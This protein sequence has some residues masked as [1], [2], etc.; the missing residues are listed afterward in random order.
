[1]I[2]LNTVK[3]IIEIS[4]WRDIVERPHFRSNINPTNVD[5]KEIIGS[6]Q[7]P[8]DVPCG[9]TTCHQPHKRGYIVVTKEGYETNIGKDCGKNYFSVDFVEMK[10]RFDRDVKTSLQRDNVRKAKETASQ[11]LEHVEGLRKQPKGADWIYSRIERLR[12]RGVI[13]EAAANEIRKMLKE[14]RKELLSSRLASKEERE[15]DFSMNPS[16][17]DKFRGQPY[18]I[19]IVTGSINHLEAM[20]KDNDLK[21]LLIRSVTQTLRQ[22]IDCD[23]DNLVILPKKQC[24]HK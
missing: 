20:S 10:T 19:T 14:R 16:L 17:E 4:S 21:E 12:N 6:Y 18:Y 11:L 2:A 13:G 15:R 23:V 1:M 5:L 7:F 9:L 22:L 3:G 24:V 8:E